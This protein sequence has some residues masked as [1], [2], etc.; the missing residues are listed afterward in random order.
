MACFF[1]LVTNTNMAISI[2]AGTLALMFL[3]HSQA[4]D[5]SVQGIF[6][7]PLARDAQVSQAQWRSLLQT[8]KTDG[9]SHI[10]FQWS[11]YEDVR[12]VGKDKPLDKIIDLLAL[13]NMTWSMGLKMPSDYYST[14]EQP[15]TVKKAQALPQWFKQ[16]RILMT[17]LIIAGY[18]QKQGFAGWYL[19]M[20]VSAPYLEGD[21]LQAWQAGI[22]D[23]LRFTSYPIAISFFP[24]S[25]GTNS[26][27]DEFYAAVSQPRVDILMQ[28]SNGLSDAQ[29]RLHSASLPCD[30]SVIIE[31]FKQ[32]SAQNEPFKAIKNSIPKDLYGRTCHAQYIFSLRY[33]PYSDD[34]PLTD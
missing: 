16:N 3:L 5:A 23:L 2:K 9:I 10:I 32:V 19:P 17:N 15:S 4:L 33:Q 24:S 14:M 7:Q 31:N 26:T 20:E 11:E 29:K 18:S 28:L 13:Q 34:L 25:Y 12:F 8:L 21:M 1:L 30:V 6:Y 22:Q 27:F